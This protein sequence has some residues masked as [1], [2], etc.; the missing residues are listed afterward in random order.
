MGP[1]GR[2]DGRP[3]QKTNY[4]GLGDLYA[5]SKVWNTKSDNAN[6]KRQTQEDRMDQTPAIDWTA[7]VDGYC[8]RLG[9]EFWA[10]PINAVTNLAFLCVAVW[11]WPRT[12]GLGRFLTAI[13][14]AIG[15]GS[16]LF[17]TYAQP[18]AAVA[19]VVPI[20]LFI[21]VYIFA[22]NRD[23]WTLPW[24]WAFAATLLFFPYAAVI[25]WLLG[26]TGF[27]LHGTEGY[28]PVPLLILGYSVAL[29]RRYPTTAQGLFIGA[30]I[31]LVSM[32]A[33]TIDMPLCGQISHGTHFAWHILNAVM[34]G[35]MIHVWTRHVLAT[36]ARGG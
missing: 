4:S 31:L 35:W 11:M 12:M 17:H 10:E 21:L 27:D 8:E 15:V 14:F 28:V 24:Y 20:V 22:I 13:L 5:S 3:H 30:G 23:V 32:T 29:R 2:W 16:G 6:A 9:P 7:A 33:R 1:D 34:L 36:K 26:L 18:W 25:S 19:D